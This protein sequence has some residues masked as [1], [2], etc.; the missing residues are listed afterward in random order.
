MPVYGCVRSTSL[1]SAVRGLKGVY[2]HENEE[3]ELWAERGGA[4]TG[5]SS[6]IE[7]L[8]PSAL[9]WICIIILPYAEFV[10]AEDI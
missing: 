3:L 2:G 7:P 8:E 9:L 1:S 4:G 5:C 6:E 10:V